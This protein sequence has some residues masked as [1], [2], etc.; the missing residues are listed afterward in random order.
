MKQEHLQVIEKSILNDKT[1]LQ[2]VDNKKEIENID[3]MLDIFK[4]YETELVNLNLELLKPYLDDTTDVFVTLEFIQC[5]LLGNMNNQLDFELDEEQRS[6]IVWICKMLETKRQELSSIP[7]LSSEEKYQIEK[8]LK[9]NQE[10]YDILLNQPNIYLSSSMIT[11]LA[12]TI[13]LSK[14]ELY[15]FYQDLIERNN[16]I[17]LKEL[18]KIKV[19]DIDLKIDKVENK[20]LV[21]EE[22]K[23][24]TSNEEKNN[25][26]TNEEKIEPSLENYLSQIEDDYE[27]TAKEEF[28]TEEEIKKINLEENEDVSNIEE[29]EY[30]AL[31]NEEKYLENDNHIEKNNSDLLS[32]KP[33]HL[34]MP[35]LEDALNENLDD[36]ANILKNPNQILEN[37]NI[38]NKQDD[39][40]NEEPLL[41]KLS[42]DIKEVVI[43]QN[44]KEHAKEILS[45]LKENSFMKI[46]EY[47]LDDLIIYSSKQ[48]LETIFK[49]AK[50]E[51]ISNRILEQI[52]SVFLDRK[53]VY[54]EDNNYGNFYNFVNNIK[55]LKQY[56][57]DI[58]KVV[59]NSLAILIIPNEKLIK[60]LK[61][62]KL[63]KIPF[64]NRAN[65]EE[66][67]FLLADD[68]ASNIDKYIESSLEIYAKE[69]TAKLINPDRIVF[70]R[71]YY[72]NQKHL[73]YICQFEKDNSYIWLDKEIS[74]KNG[75]GITEENYLEKTD[76]IVL[77]KQDIYEHIIYNDSNKV[78][79]TILEH[80]FIKEL[81]HYRFNNQ[82]YYQINSIKISRVKV[83][84]VF[85]ALLKHEIPT[86]DAL[87]Y[88][89]IYN[90][91][92]NEKQFNTLRQAVD[93][94]CE[95]KVV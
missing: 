53:S 69:K 57:I 20:N 52:P 24:D 31:E 32:V 56:N 77:P 84:R 68:L 49:I 11:S 5:L 62:A 71:L 22:I 26:E 38:D 14:E 60:N 81:E 25:L 72:A 30:L 10:A 63:Y 65:H 85:Y 79:K 2:E 40:F 1:R 45:V 16:Q 95:E 37:H 67:S 35:S 76:T 80:P 75:F 15:L 94:I 28:L 91:I 33:D 82:N 58:L 64:I 8:R 55:V 88:A 39:I 87:L 43:K 9:T 90:T 12:S 7:K 27:E 42:S 61:V 41:Q 83:L 44:L 86:K 73:Q 34:T 74:S 18:N 3:R 19:P 4:N 66:Y 70:Y 51:N 48:I 47:L 50:E 78:D 46:T 29:N 59:K 93:E 13:S 17:Y 89:I 54:H 21:D 92:L 36:K 23:P 6:L